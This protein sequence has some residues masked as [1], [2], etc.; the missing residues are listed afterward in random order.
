MSI[1]IILAFVLTFVYFVAGTANAS[2]L[3]CNYF[4]AM[5][6]VEGVFVSRSNLCYHKTRNFLPTFPLCASRFEGL[7]ES[8]LSYEEALDRLPPGQRKQHES[9]YHFGF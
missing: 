8:P 4:V 7:H 2:V 1:L 5:G 3:G 6:W 9:R